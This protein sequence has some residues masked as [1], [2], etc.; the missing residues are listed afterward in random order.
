MRSRPFS[1]AVAVG[2]VAIGI[3]APASARPSLTRSLGS[4]SWHVIARVFANAGPSPSTFTA[5]TAQT[6]TSAWAFES[7]GS[8]ASPIVAWRLTGSTWSKAPFPE[9]YGS[10][11]IEATGT[12]PTGVYVATS[13]GALLTW[14]GT[15][16]TLVSRFA[17]IADIGA[18]GAHDLWLTGRR[19]ASPKSG[20][21]WHLLGG[22]WSR[23]SGRWYG[24]L[25]VVSD[26]AIFSVTPTAMEEF[27]GR[28]WK[29]TSLASLLPPKR[30]LCLPRVSSVEA[31][32]PTD[33][34]VTAAGGCQD[35]S[36]P[37]RLLH[38]VGTTWSIAA[39]RAEAEGYAYPAGGGS[40]WIP[41]KAFACVGCTV[42][43]HLA[44]GKLTRVS[45]PVGQLGGVTLNGGIATARGS[46]DS[47]AAGW[48]LK[49]ART[50]C[51][52]RHARAVLLQ[53]DP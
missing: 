37:F 32:T 26:H 35:Y 2:L 27:N 30:P 22:R 50:S 6:S 25:D 17:A 33:V 53:Y 36:G 52:F 24:A 39:D 47:I 11:V 28:S 23:P 1:V 19:T 20:G 16:W 31:L 40:L 34:W 15:R 10:R 48:S 21:L 38:R 7:T 5:V 9:S 49:C 29:V 42:M 3:A 8:R 41:T 45:L 46:T 4:P 12:T 44:R 43:L 18:S 51:D 13:R 14:S